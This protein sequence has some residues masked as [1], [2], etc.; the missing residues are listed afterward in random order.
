MKYE[1]NAI[2]IPGLAKMCRCPTS[3][4]VAT[5]MQDSRATK[6]LV[7]RFSIFFHE[8][9]NYEALLKFNDNKKISRSIM[10]I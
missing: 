8:K 3:I 7:G 2:K 5:M 9:S 4:L 1:Q 6:N 10:L